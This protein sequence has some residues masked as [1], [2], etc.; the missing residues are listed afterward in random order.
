MKTNYTVSNRKSTKMYASNDSIAEAIHFLKDSNS[1]RS[2]DEGLK[3]LLVKKGFKGDIHNPYEVANHLISKLHHIG[4]SIKDITVI[5][6]FID[7]PQRVDKPRPKI[8]AGSRLKIYEICFALELSIDETIWFFEHV[9]YDRPFNCHTIDEAVYYFSFLNHL[10]YHEARSLIAEIKYTSSNNLS[11]CPIE[12]NYT[13]FIQDR[14][15]EFESVEELKTFLITHKENFHSW[16]HSAL[17]TLNALIEQLIGPPESKIEIDTLKR[18]L[19]RKMHASNTHMTIELS[20]Y[21]CCGLLIK[22]IIYDAQNQTYES[23]AQYILDAIK[24]KNIRKHT[25]ILERLLL[26]ATGLKKNHQIPYVVR[27]NFPSKK[28]LSD[29]LSHE[30]MSTSKSYDSIRKAIILLDFYRFWI[31]IK[32][33]KEQFDMKKEDLSEIYREEA[34]DLLYSCGYHTLFDGNPYDWIFLCAAQSEDPIKYFR[35][36]ISELLPNNF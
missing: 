18:T 4:S 34:N 23:V 36:Y 9:Y 5:S 16:N 14:I 3:Q 24:D 6:W 22:E 21:S 33:D 11:L 1:F 27:N 31:S 8:E 30:K 10:N 19:T 26:T 20:N 29:V 28:T 2:F 15:S 13:Q 17:L 7:N 35:S 12:A 32:L 25:F